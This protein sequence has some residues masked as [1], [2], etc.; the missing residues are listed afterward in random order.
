VDLDQLRT[1][2]F[3]LRVAVPVRFAGLS[4]ARNV[5]HIIAVAKWFTGSGIPYKEPAKMTGFLGFLR[6]GRFRARSVSGDAAAHRATFV[7]YLEP[8]PMDRDDPGR[9]SAFTQNDV[10]ANSLESATVDKI[11]HALAVANPSAICYC[12]GAFAFR[13]IT[14]IPDEHNAPALAVSVFDGPNRFLCRTD[15]TAFAAVK[16]IAFNRCIVDSHSHLYRFSVNRLAARETSCGR[17]SCTVGTPHPKW[18]RSPKDMIGKTDA[19]ESRIS[20]EACAQDGDVLRCIFG[21]H[22]ALAFAKDH[23]EHTVHA[24]GIEGQSIYGLLPQSYIR[25]ILR[26]SYIYARIDPW[27]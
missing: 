25:Q 11:N 1:V 12:A 10:T 16:R 13:A 17:V 19:E 24:V 27:I 14:L 15:V 21:A 20:L 9:R 2:A 4:G 6:R 18:I 22:A 3:N 8:A 7:R 26:I 5:G 23:V